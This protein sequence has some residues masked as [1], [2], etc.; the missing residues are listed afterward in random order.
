M[1]LHFPPKA[2]NKQA[3]LGTIFNHCFWK[4][5]EFST[6]VDREEEHCCTFMGDE[7]KEHECG[8]VHGHQRRKNKVRNRK[9]IHF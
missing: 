2:M 5:Q 3:R 6:V 1:L 7:E 4:M 8:T 9:G